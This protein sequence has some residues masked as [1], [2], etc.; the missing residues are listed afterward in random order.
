MNDLSE[1]IRAL[2]EGSSGE[3][4]FPKL[5]SELT[6]R[7]WDRL[8]RD[9]ALSQGTY[10]TERVFCRSVSAPR[11]IITYLKAFP[12]IGGEEVTIAAEALS[13]G[14]V[15]L[16]RKAGVCF[17]SSEEVLNTTVLACIKEA[18]LIVNEVP[19][20]LR[21]VASLVRSLH[22]IRPANSDYDTS[23]SEPQVPFS[24]FVSVP[25]RRIENDALRVAEAIVHEAMHLQL[26]LIERHVELVKGDGKKCK[27]YFSPWRREFRTTGGIL[28]GLYVFCVVSQFL[29]R[30]QFRLQDYV[31]G[32]RTEIRK[33]VV[34]LREFWTSE[35]LTKIGADFGRR[36]ITEQTAD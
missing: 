21:T 4:W 2:L 20:L 3:P 17:Y 22:V 32:R 30:T 14:S 11:N 26:T 19:S 29:G 8:R 13:E 5:T 28:H 34:S 1:R 31:I 24:I 12:S 33:Q 36:L 18:L 35:D 27:K 23:F 25:Q 16:Y 9:I 10:G 7:E 6:A 15:Y